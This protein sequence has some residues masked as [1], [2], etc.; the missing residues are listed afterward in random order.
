MK[1][2]GESGRNYIRLPLLMAERCLECGARQNSETSL[3]HAKTHLQS[4]GLYTVCRL[5][6]QVASRGSTR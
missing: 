6:Y 4:T 1:R 2:M 5:L 3:G